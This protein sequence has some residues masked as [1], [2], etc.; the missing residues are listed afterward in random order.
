MSNWKMD[1]K[2]ALIVMHMQQGLVGKGTFIPG[3]FGPAKKGIVESGMIAHIHDLL[4]AFRDKKLPIVFVSALPNPI[5]VVPAYGFLYR[6][7]EEAEVSE[8][9]LT[10]Q[11]V[12]ENLEVMPEMERRP[13]EP[14]LF[15]WLIG[16]F[17]NSGL[18]AVLKLANVKTVVLVGFAQHSV[19]YS[20]A[21]QA[22]DL[23]YSTIIPSDASVVFI[24]RE[25]PGATPELDKKVSEVVLEVMAPSISLVTTTADVI[26]H[27]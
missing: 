16:A 12:R 7:I 6:K 26:A 18:D 15:N 13:T 20:T 21:V 1:G 4:K 11:R 19:V 22:G 14:L 24:P 2:P 17:T 8:S 23:W 9:I 27:L 5:G 25:N 10:S 3:W